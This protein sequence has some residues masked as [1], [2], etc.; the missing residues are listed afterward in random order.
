M[1]N[2]LEILEQSYYEHFKSAKDLAMYL[3]L[4]HPKRL[5][6]EVTLNQMITEINNI[7]N[8]KI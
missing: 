2:K 5:L 1:S 6:L 3:P 4:N 8:K 7:K